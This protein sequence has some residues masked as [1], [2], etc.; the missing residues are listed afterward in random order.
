MSRRIASAICTE[1]PDSPVPEWVELIPAPSA[2]GLIR[3]KDGRTY[4]M[5][6]PA[7]V[8]ANFPHPLP[9]DINHS[10]ERA[11]AL[12]Q[13]SPA[14]GW[15]EEL[16][17]RENALW[18]RVRWLARGEQAVSGQEY[19]FLSPVFRY[20]EANGE[21]HSLKSVALLNTPN[22]TLALNSAED[23]ETPMNII[24]A[25]ILTALGLAAAATE[26]DVLNAISKLKGDLKTAENSAQERTN[27]TLFVP[28]SDYDQV[29]KRAENAEKSAKDRDAADRAKQIDAAIEGALKAGKIAPASADYHRT[30]CN[31]EGGLENFKKFV[32]GAAPIVTA[33]VPD[34]TKVTGQ[35]LSLNAEEKATCLQMGISEEKYAAE[36]ESLRS[37]GLIR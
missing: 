5:S 34:P 19:R 13:E 16:Q 15:I 25:T 29:L 2:D 8:A 6:K 7:A 11:A 17:V 22:F 30:A 33:D 31:S 1:L 35:G 14:A 23:T 24:P 28:R 21:I 27:L 4:R 32:E 37:A 18:G 9:V 10:T 36:R 3:G 26:A 12:G 20:D